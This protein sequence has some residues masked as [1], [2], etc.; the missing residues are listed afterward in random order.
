MICLQ[1]LRGGPVRRGRLSLTDYCTTSTMP[2]AGKVEFRLSSD[3]ARK[4][5]SVAVVV[6]IIL[7]RL[8]ER[9]WTGWLPI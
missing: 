2:C 3:K 1:V 4:R 9:Q 7:S 8:D 5:V 6:L